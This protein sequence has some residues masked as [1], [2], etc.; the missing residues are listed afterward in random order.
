[1]AIWG[2]IPLGHAVVFPHG[3]YVVGEVGRVEDFDR[4]KA[5]EVDF[6][7]RDKET[8]VRLWAVRVLDADPESRRG[9][10]EVVVKIPAEVQPVPPET[11]PGL[12][13]RPVEFVGLVGI[14]YIDS[15]RATPRLAWSLRATGMHAPGHGSA[16][17]SGSASSAAKAG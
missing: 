16:S 2:A 17:S 11:A 9:Q 10:A 5:G 12:P 15:Q 6:Q 7:S 14:P 1:M 8:G 13:F 3:A 4:R